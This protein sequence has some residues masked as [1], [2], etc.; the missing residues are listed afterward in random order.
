M[1]RLYNCVINERQAWFGVPRTDRS[2]VTGAKLTRGNC[3]PQAERPRPGRS[4]K[5]SVQDLFD[6]CLCRS[7][8]NSRAP[9]K[10][11]TRG[12]STRRR[13]GTACSTRRWGLGRLGINNRYELNVAKEGSAVAALG[14]GRSGSSN[15]LDGLTESVHLRRTYWSRMPL[16]HVKQQ[17][18]FVRWVDTISKLQLDQTSSEPTMPVK[19]QRRESVQRSA[20]PVSTALGFQENRANGYILRR[21]WPNATRVR[22]LEKRDVQIQ[23]LILRSLASMN[24]SDLLR[25]AA[26]SHTEA[27]LD[28]TWQLG[29]RHPHSL[30]NYYFKSD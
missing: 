19:Y 11:E 1:P 28:R 2:N 30:R 13:N 20:S 15:K 18:S 5:Q 8:I 27:K 4:P 10:P 21:A 3:S 29:K 22:T 26:A 17:G 14:T 16:K 24:R 25:R 6:H 7:L 23:G 12:C 9:I